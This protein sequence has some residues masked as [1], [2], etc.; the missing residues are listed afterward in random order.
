MNRLLR[1]KEVM[2]LTGIARSTIHALA[3]DDK[4]PKPVKIREGGRASGWYESEIHDWIN[5]GR[6]DPKR[7]ETASPIINHEN[8]RNCISLDTF[9]LR[10]QFAASALTGLLANTKL[11][12]QANEKFKGERANEWFTETAYSF[13]DA[14]LA[15]RSK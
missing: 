11:I 14:M 7:R 4:F 10:D 12:S 5:R 1:A 15:E 2:A 3:A 8:R 6:T 13:A 9:R